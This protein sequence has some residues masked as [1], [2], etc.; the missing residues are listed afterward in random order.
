MHS[1]WSDWTST[2]HRH[3]IKVFNSWM[4]RLN[5]KHRL[6]IRYFWESINRLSILCSWGISPKHLI[7]SVNTLHV[8]D[9]VKI[10]LIDHTLSLLI[11]VKWH[12][13]RCEWFTLL[14]SMIKPW[15]IIFIKVSLWWS[16]TLS[17]ISFFNMIIDCCISLLC[18]RTKQK[19]LFHSLCILFSS[20]HH[21]LIEFIK[22]L[23]SI[24]PHIF[25]LFYL[26]L[27]ISLGHECAVFYFLSLLLFKL[28]H[29][30]SSFIL[31]MF[32][33]LL[34]VWFNISIIAATILALILWLMD[35]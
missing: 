19:I 23:L 15:C 25:L 20:P 26:F 28:L 34:K 3:S 16:S 11:W 24:F 10:L 13:P 4:S 33:Q 14:T 31:S 22:L 21:E 8:W 7:Y 6:V 9:I 18:C 30:L 1:R 5:L 27:L 12:C 32:N 35:L 2:N 17:M 29:P